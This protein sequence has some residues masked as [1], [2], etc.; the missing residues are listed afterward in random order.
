[1][2]RTATPIFSNDPKGIDRSR[3]SG[4]KML[5]IE[6]GARLDQTAPWLLVDPTGVQTV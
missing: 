5:F 6:F 3:A 2:E 1:M 4:N